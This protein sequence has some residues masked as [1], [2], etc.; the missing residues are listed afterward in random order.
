M[1]RCDGTEAGTI[2]VKDINP[3][4]PRYFYGPD[5]LTAVGGTLFFTTDDGV[6]GEEL[7]TSDGTEAGT[8]VVNDTNKGGSFSVAKKGTANTRKGTMKVK[9]DVDATGRVNVAPVGN[10]KLK[11]TFK[12]S[13]TGGRVTVTLTPTKAG[14]KKLKRTGKLSIR[15]RFTFTPCGVTDTSVVRRYTLRMR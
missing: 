10:S 14:V 1:W 4:T 7:W 6:I 13:A 3:N 2:L 5:S 9:V 15:A 12:D 11:R 8:V